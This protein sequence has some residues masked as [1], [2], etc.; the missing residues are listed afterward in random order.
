MKARMS[1]RRGRN[2][3]TWAASQDNAIKATLELD[4][5]LA[6]TQPDGPLT[7]LIHI[8]R[9]QGSGRADGRGRVHSADP[10]M[11]LAVALAVFLG[12]S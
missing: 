2:E 3:Y 5:I 6:R 12:E 10:C 1:N 7:S 9:L 8:E 11:A 4:G